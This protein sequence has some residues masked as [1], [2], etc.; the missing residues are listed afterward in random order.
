MQIIVNT[1]DVVHESLDGEVV[2][3]NLRNGR[4]YSLEDTGAELW[5]WLL[6]EGDAA[7]LVSRVS[8]KYRDSGEIEA[9]VTCFL[10][11]LVEEGLVALVPSDSAEAKRYPPASAD[12]PVFQTPV[13]AKHVD[14]EGLLLLDP[15]HDVSERG[16]PDLKEQ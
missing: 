16:W 5:E 11:S 12:A 10:E 6:A 2:L 13:L 14:M 9:G 4:Y 8:S 3:V 15:V 7:Q 1:E